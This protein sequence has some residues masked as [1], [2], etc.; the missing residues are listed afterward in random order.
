VGGRVEV[1]KLRLPVADLSEIEDE[2]GERI[3]IISIR[4]VAPPEK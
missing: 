2:A 3:I 1:E 4:G